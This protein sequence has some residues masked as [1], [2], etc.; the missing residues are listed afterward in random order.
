MTVTAVGC[1]RLWI[2]AA[3]CRLLQQLPP[4]STAAAFFNS[5]RALPPSSIA[6]TVYTL[7]AMRILIFFF[8]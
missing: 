7:R 3:C 4:Y 5:C 6:V 2:V 8:K 1:H